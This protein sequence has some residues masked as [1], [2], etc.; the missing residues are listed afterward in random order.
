[1]V[2]SDDTGALEGTVEDADGKPVAGWVMV[3]REGRSPRN[4]MSQAD[5][6]FTVPTLAPG[7]Y[8]VCAWDDWQQVEYANADWM[9]RNAAPVR[10][11]VEGGQTVQVRLRQQ[12]TPPL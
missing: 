1:M 7:D 12:K 2:L 6:H 10:A 9:Q 8:T 11:T 5:G 3:L 4:I